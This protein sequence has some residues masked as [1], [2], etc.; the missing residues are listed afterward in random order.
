MAERKHFSLGRSKSFVRY[1]DL[2]IAKLL[3]SEYWR[4]D[5]EV[6]CADHLSPYGDILNKEQIE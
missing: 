5:V 2:E 6:K 4:C 1:K 3:S